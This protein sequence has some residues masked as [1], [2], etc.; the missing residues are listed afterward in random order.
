MLVAFLIAM[1]FYSKK[2]CFVCEN[3]AFNFFIEPKVP[4]LENS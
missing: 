4:V 1:D 3:C 2:I